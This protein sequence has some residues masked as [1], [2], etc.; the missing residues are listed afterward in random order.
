LANA[1]DVRCLD[2][3]DGFNDIES[4]RMSNLLSC[5]EGQKAEGFKFKEVSFANIL[6]VGK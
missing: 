1:D 5:A 3:S 4:A 2:I 6:S